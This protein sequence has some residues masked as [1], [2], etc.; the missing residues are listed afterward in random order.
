MV[1][2]QAYLSTSPRL[3]IAG[4]LELPRASALL[5]GWKVEGLFGELM[6]S[7]P[8]SFRFYSSEHL[9]LS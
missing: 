5:V 1:S 3:N 8:L 6:M 4:F 9:S 7:S 2:P